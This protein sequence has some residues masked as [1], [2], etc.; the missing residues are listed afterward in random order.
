M[1]TLTLNFGFVTNS[2]S[3][4]HSFD[5]ELLADPE[6]DAFLKA[7]ELLD[8]R[9]GEKLAWRNFCA[10]FLTTTEQKKRA[11]EM[12]AEYPELD[13]QVDHNNSIVVIYCDETISF[14]S[15][16]CKLL[17]R[18]AKRLGRG[19]LGHESFN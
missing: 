16:L 8:G 18:A 7:F 15:F 19:N 13:L 3:V 10:S 14:A 1:R 4:I 5:R 17:K 2:S 6:V 11:E 9:I 12:L